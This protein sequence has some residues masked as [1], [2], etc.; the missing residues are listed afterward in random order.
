MLQYAAD[1][2]KVLATLL[3]VGVMDDARAD[4][5]GSGNL[6]LTL[7]ENLSQVCLQ[8]SKDQPTLGDLTHGS[9]TELEDAPTWLDINAFVRCRFTYHY[10]ITHHVALV[11]LGSPV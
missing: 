1:S 11:L 7:I 10:G 3:V 9:L 6:Q 5:V 8:H 2:M 4:I